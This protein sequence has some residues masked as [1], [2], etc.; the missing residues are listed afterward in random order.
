MK[1]IISLILLMLY[2][3]GVIAGI[4]YL[5]YYKEWHVAIGVLAVSVMALPTA[6]K[7]FKYIQD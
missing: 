4:G 5:V 7:I 2:I 3:F 1:K 6:K